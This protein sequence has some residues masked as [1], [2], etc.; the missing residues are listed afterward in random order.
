[1]ATGDRR[2]IERY[3]QGMITLAP[4]LAVM[5]LSASDS[6]M[7]RG[8]SH[9][10]ARYR[11]AHLRDV[12]YDLSLDV[13]RRDTVVGSVEVSFT[14]VNGGDV[15]V[16]FRGHSLSAVRVNGVEAEIADDGA[17]RNALTYNGA[18]LRIPAARLK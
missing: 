10:L 17:S 12:R 6:L 2:P 18:H 16:D 15:I 11:A 9:E 13:T 5:M 14:R 3:I 4:L 8:V 1:M 7:A